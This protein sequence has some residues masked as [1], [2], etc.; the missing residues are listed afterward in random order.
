MTFSFKDLEKSKSV[1]LL[2]DAAEYQKITVDVIKNLVNIAVCY[3]TL[4]IPHDSLR[5]IFEDRKVSLTDVVFIDGITSSIKGV[6]KEEKGCYFIS[7]PGAFTELSLAISKFLRHNFDVLIF[8]SITNL[9]TYRDKAVVEQFLLKLI[10][11]IG[12]SKKTKGIFYALNLDS[13]KNL[14]KMATS[15][16]E[17]VVGPKF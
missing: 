2:M 12:L 9:S 8:D 1:L 16:V 6:G 10:N 13:E 11:E 7:S 14:I 3:A 15:H 17:K 4:N 5:D